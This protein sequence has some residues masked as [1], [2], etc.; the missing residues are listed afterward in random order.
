M[1]IYVMELCLMNV[2]LLNIVYRKKLKLLI[3]LSLYQLNYTI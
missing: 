3:Q 1:I 2:K